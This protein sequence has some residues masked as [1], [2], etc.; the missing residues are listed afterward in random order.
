MDGLAIVGRLRLWPTYGASDED[1]TKR[2]LSR[3]AAPSDEVER[4][5]ATGVELDVESRGR[6]DR[7]RLV[8]SNAGLGM[9]G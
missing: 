8:I 5:L 7:S 4:L 1:E 2:I 6:R 9:L 3:V